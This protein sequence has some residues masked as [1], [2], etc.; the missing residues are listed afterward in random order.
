MQTTFIRDNQEYNLRNGY[1]LTPRLL[2]VCK[3]NTI[4]IKS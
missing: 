3:H 4:I 1:T 2:S